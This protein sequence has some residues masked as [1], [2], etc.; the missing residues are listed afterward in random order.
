MLNFSVNRLSDK[1]LPQQVYDQIS[2]R[3]LNNEFQAGERLPSSRELAT[4]IGVSRNVVLEAYD[5]LMIEGYIEVRPGSGTYVSQG[6][7]LLVKKSE[8]PSLSEDQHIVSDLFP[9]VD[10]IDFKASNPAMDYFP[11]SI[12]GNLTKEVCL[13][14]ED[15]LFGYNPSQGITEL[16]NV[17]RRYLSRVRGVNCHPE[18]IIITT[19]ATQGLYLITK[20]LTTQ[21][22]KV[23]IE[24]PIADEMLPIFQNAGADVLPVP[25]DERG[26]VTDS[27]PTH[28]D[29]SFIFVVPSHQFP[30]GGTLPIQ[31]RIQLIEY[32]R[33]HN[34][35]IVEDDYDSEFTYEGIPVASMQGLDPENV[36]YV[37][38][39]SKILS[40]SLRI[41]YM[42]LPWGL[43]RQ[44]RQKKWYLDRHTGTI[45]Q[46]VLAHFI[47]EGYLDRHVRR[48][49]GI[50]KQR[51][52]AMV[53]SISKHFSNFKIHGKAAGMH[54]VLELEGV[55]FTEKLVNRIKDQ[56]VIVYPIKPYAISKR[57]HK[58][59]IVMGYGSLT[60]DLIEEGVS[61]I[62]TVLENF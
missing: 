58:N 32:A 26:I 45:D 43:V 25:V 30:L 31:R 5:Q 35:Y 3:I 18:Q 1:T 16:R 56:G 15:R 23:I 41:G 4:N 52:K 12:W 57:K 21:N 37:G 60:E 10:S 27:L 22:K 8:Q 46:M 49:K 17:L 9:S 7:S 55:D 40:P 54:L 59:K 50:Y 2:N 34:A 20:F 29:P 28:H 44:I 39:F 38:T 19:G 61:R 47:K 11:R 14:S 53:H 51:R 42:V 48:M 36:I 13:Q 33:E 62:K 6:S 24:D